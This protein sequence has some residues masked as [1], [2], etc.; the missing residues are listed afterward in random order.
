MEESSGLKKLYGF[1]QSTIY[2]YI[3]L[4]IFVFVLSN[5]PYSG[6]LTPL[7]EPIRSLPFFDNLI[8]SKLITVGLIFI[9]SV[10]TKAKKDINFDPLKHIF[11]PCFVGF[12]LLIGSLYAFANKEGGEI[13][14][15]LSLNEILYII[16][17]IFGAVFIHIAFDNISKLVKSGL[18]RDKFNYENESFRQTTKKVETQISVNI[19]MLYYYK[20]RI[21]KGWIN[22]TNPF[23][24]TLVLGVPGS[25][26]TFSIVIPYIKQLMRKGFTA[27]IYD[28][29]YPDLAAIAYHHY[30]I[31]RKLNIYGKNHKFHVINLGDVERS[32]RV[33]PLLPQ[34]LDT[35]DDCLET[36]EALILSLQKTDRSSGSDQFFTQS[37]INFFAACLYFFA[38]YEEGKY[39]TLSHVLAFLNRSYEEIFDTL[40]SMDELES[41]LSNFQTAYD[42][43]AFDQLEGQIGTLKIN[44]AK[45]NS[46]ESAWIFSG[47]DIDLKISDRENP[48]VLI[49]ASSPNKQSTTS[50]LNALILNRITAIINE[51]GNI[52][53]LIAAD[54]APT[55][56]IH[57]ISNL[58]A[59]ARSNQVAVLLGVQ[60][61]PQLVELYSQQRANTIVSVIGNIFS[62]PVRKKETLDWLEKLF[63]KVA[64]VREGISIDR[65]RTNI[66][67]NEH[68]DYLIPASK[69]SSLNE[70]E[71]VGQVASSKL[72]YNKDFQVNTYNCKVNIDLLKVEK[73]EKLYESIPK[74]YKFDDK[75]KILKSNFRKI[76]LDVANVVVAHARNET[77]K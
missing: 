72:K 64:Q 17:S 3:V 20:K 46:P 41:L 74:Y 36:S 40:F 10:G 19:P 37:S 42:N 47:N 32:R 70:G 69:I 56:Y 49:L 4:E 61:L 59:T 22:I 11:I 26:K 21:V 71:I 45:L 43:K 66:S 53:T 54:E 57:R 77:H 23:R 35:L 2:F 48:S 18:M 5:K 1:L 50:A 31:C 63:G 30:K 75:E 27:L 9:V 76:K 73:E 7:A 16:G 52:P 51:K 24:G 65:N 44:V 55:F 14:W 68:M 67:M 33:N 13:A 25:G 62:G 38:K 12:C 39:S 28:F 34:Y 60:E 29:K 6:F 8:F 15:A 58:I